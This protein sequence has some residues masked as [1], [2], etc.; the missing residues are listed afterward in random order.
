MELGKSVFDIL[1]INSTLIYCSN[2][3]SHFFIGCFL[4]HLTFYSDQLQIFNTVL[5]F[6]K[7]LLH[8]V[9]PASC[10]WLTVLTAN[11]LYLKLPIQSDTFFIGIGAFVR[12]LSLCLFH[13][14]FISLHSLNDW[15]DEFSD[16]LSLFLFGVD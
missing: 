5:Y 16:R 1:I 7:S 15:Y 12:R 14:I 6:F 11:Y 13:A 10:F 2:S 3:N 9:E 4:G 8:S